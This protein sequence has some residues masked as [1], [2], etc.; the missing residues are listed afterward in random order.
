M[1][2]FY[3]TLVLSI[4]L[5]SCVSCLKEMPEKGLKITIPENNPIENLQ[6]NL[7][8]EEKTQILIL[9]VPPLTVLSKDFS[10]ALIDKLIQKLLKF[11]PDVVCLDVFNSDEILFNYYYKDDLTLENLSNE[12]IKYLL[13]YRNKIK[14]KTD[15]IEFEIDSLIKSL[16][17]SRNSILAR[18]RLIDLY[19]FNFD[20]YNATLNYLHLNKSDLNKLKIDKRLI[21]ILNSIS[22]RSNENSSIGLQ[23]AHKLGLNRIYSI[24]TSSDRKI[25]NR[26]SEQLYKEMVLSEVYKTHR[27]EILNDTA[28]RKLKEGLLK[29]DLFDFFRYINLESYALVSTENNWSIYLRMFLESKL[30][31]TRIGIWETKNLR[32]ASNIREV[33]ALNPSKKILVILDVSKKTFVEEYLK[34]MSDIRIIKFEEIIN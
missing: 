12:E 7:R 4:L 16:G 13:K 17:V 14:I 3:N 9:G 5:F 18:K 24:N 32:I 11:N 8:E 15:D 29:Q 10:Y 30:D 20:L 19:I 6:K 26:I 1:F 22:K 2:R 31:R 28:D 25:L 34:S 27:R 23:V 21:Q 33:S